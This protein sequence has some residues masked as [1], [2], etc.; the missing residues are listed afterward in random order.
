MRNKRLKTIKRTNQ[1]FIHH[2]TKPTPPALQPFLTLTAPTPTKHIA[3]DAEHHALILPYAA[4][5]QPLIVRKFTPTWRAATLRP[6]GVRA[7]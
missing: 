4:D 6:A 2:A 3:Y 1:R 5:H 7:N